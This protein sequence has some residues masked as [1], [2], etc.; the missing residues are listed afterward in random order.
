MDNLGAIGGPLLA[1]FLVGLVGIRSAIG[2]SV[3]PGLLAS[4][5][6]V[7]AIR[8]TPEAE[9]R[10]HQ[11]IRLAIRPI[12]SGPL[13]RL[14]VAIA[15]FEFGN[16]AV[17]LFILRA[18]QLLEPG[19]S[20]TAAVQLALGLYVAYNVA[21]TLVSV[22]AGRIG[23]RRGST[24]VLTVGIALFGASYVGFAIGGSTVLALAPAF[25]LSGVAIGCVET[26]QNAAVASVAPTD[27][28]GSAFGVFAA[29]QSFGNLAASAVAGVLWTAVAPMV[30]FAYLAAWMLIA[31]M[32]LLGIRSRSANA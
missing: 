18:T 28:R 6:I 19:W 2:L 3:I 12:L 11:R 1:I 8:H 14:M 22:P 9:K 16:V 7:Y 24:V 31:L 21:A 15:A 20:H 4:L 17:T 30:S 26:S 32:A 23:D 10:Q 13:G 5:A 27:L 25:L 29:I